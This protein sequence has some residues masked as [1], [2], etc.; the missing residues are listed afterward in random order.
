[1]KRMSKATALQRCKSHWEDLATSGSRFKAEFLNRVK[2]Y[3]INGCYCCEYTNDKKT[4]C[5]ACPLKGYAWDKCMD[6]LSYYRAWLE[7]NTVE[8]RSFWANK[9]VGACDK[10]LAKKPKEFLGGD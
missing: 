9:I 3:P 1:M 6:K 5:N 2:E 8:E 10:A 7:S 4:G